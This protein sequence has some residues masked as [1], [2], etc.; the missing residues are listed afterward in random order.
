MAQWVDLMFPSLEQGTR[1]QA[2]RTP[3]K[4]QKRG[5]NKVRMKEVRIKRNT[6][7]PPTLSI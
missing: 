5:A 7:T 4:M 3:M 6:Y 1:R 2:I